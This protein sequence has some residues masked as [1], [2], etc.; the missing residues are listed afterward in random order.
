VELLDVDGGCNVFSRALTNFAKH[1]LS[2]SSIALQ[3]SLGQHAL[4]LLWLS[5]LS[6]AD[7]K[8]PFLTSIL[9]VHLFSVTGVNIWDPRFIISAG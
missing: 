4:L 6:W 8:L 5:H 2:G 9:P 7:R 1:V 3:E